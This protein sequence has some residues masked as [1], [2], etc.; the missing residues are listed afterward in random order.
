M[1]KKK[2]KNKE[3][4]LTELQEPIKYH[5]VYWQMHN[6]SPLRRVV[7]VRRRRKVKE[8]MPKTF[9]HLKKS[10]NLLNIYLRSSKT[11]SKK[12]LRIFILRHHNQTV[13]IQTKWRCVTRMAKM[14]KGLRSL[15]NNKLTKM[16]KGF[17]FL[18]DVQNGVD[19]LEY[20]F[21]FYVDSTNTYY[22]TQ[23]LHS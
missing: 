5:Q 2:R 22:I 6:W 10:N 14:K 17:A 1:K 11:P 4:K 23:Q 7:M 18:V 12:N 15:A 21:H 19:T 8:I 13:K 3:E 9:P 20:I 16:K